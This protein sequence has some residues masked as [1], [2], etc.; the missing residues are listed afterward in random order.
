MIKMQSA[1]KVLGKNAGSYTSASGAV[2]PT[3]SL[4]T[5]ANG[6]A[7]NVDVP[8]EVF[9]SVEDGRTYILEGDI[10]TTKYGKY[11]SFKNV[12]QDITDSKEKK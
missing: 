4:A 1:I 6:R 2:V 3:Y 8:L 9:Q 5:I 12:L 7:E 10:G 11:W